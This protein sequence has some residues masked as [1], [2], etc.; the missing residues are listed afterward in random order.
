MAGY[1]ENGQPLL[2]GM[3]FKHMSSGDRSDYI[4]CY[5]DI[6]DTIKKVY[7][8]GMLCSQLEHMLRGIIREDERR[9]T[10][11][12]I[13]GPISIIKINT[14]NTTSYI[15]NDFSKYPEGHGKWKKVKRWY[16]IEGS[17]QE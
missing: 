11:Y 1:L 10:T 6:M 13:G 17:P 15:Q 4:S 14:D 3:N 16:N 8:P 12:L 5:T 9:D 2:V 7:K